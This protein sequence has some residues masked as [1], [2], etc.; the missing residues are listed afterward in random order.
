MIRAVHR[1]PWSAALVIGVVVGLSPLHAQWLNF[2]TSGVPRTPDGNPNRSAPAPRDASGK[3]DFSGVWENDGFDPNR[4][5]GLDAGGPPKTPFFEI[6]HGMTG[7]PPY[8]P[9][10]A[11]LT[12]KRKADFGRDN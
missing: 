12:A 2:P 1:W 7:P 10:A 4:A 8:Q 5:E 11:E 9:W 6:V 3:P